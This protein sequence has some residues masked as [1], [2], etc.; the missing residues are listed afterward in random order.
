MFFQ[1]RA[2]FSRRSSMAYMLQSNIKNFVIPKDMFYINIGPFTVIT[3]SEIL[4][5]L[6]FLSDLKKILIT[7]KTEIRCDL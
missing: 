6:L 1:E 3:N 7:G 5:T 4:M 2:V